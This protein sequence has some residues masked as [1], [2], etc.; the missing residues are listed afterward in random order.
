VSQDH[1]RR[2]RAFLRRS[3][4]SLELIVLSLVRLR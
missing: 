2:A 4:V 3:I 1:D